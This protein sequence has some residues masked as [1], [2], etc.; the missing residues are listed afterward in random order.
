MESSCAAEEEEK[1]H[2]PHSDQIDDDVFCDDIL[3][4]NNPP[5]SC[6]SD[7]ATNT[8]PISYQNHLIDVTKI[9][10]PIILSEIFQNTLPLIDL[11][12]VGQLGKDELAAA[13]LATVWFNLWNGTMTGFMTAIDTFLAQSY[14]ANQYENFGVWTGNSLVITMG[15]TILVSGVI[16]TCG[17]VMHFFGQQPD[18]ADAAGEFSYRLIPGLFPYYAF[19]VLTKYLQSQNK[20]LPSL[21]I[22]FVANGLNA[23]FNWRLIYRVGG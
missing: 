13:A 11:A 9:T 15:T 14:G 22:G 8:T 6:S 18:L 12:F 17:P 21:I 10:Y 3:H 4:H 7:I 2:P 1:S 20:L 19:K 23:L 16:A 5:Q